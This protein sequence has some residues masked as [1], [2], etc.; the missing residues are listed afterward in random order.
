MRLESS[1]GPN[2]NAKRSQHCEKIKTKANHPKIIHQKGLNRLRAREEKK[3]ENTEKAS[4]DSLSLSLVQESERE[5]CRG[6]S[7][8]V[9]VAMYRRIANPPLLSRS[10]SPS[11]RS[12]SSCRLQNTPVGSTFQGFITIVPTSRSKFREPILN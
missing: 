10:T 3:K 6:C 11:A 8:H 2:F 1:V 5:S 4:S 12:P 7:L 9:L